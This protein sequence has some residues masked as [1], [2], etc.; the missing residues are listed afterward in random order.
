MVLL[1]EGC[2]LRA[3]IRVGFETVLDSVEDTVRGASL[4]HHLDD[5]EDRNQ[6]ASDDCQEDA[7]PWGGGEN[8]R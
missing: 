4:T 5:E 3:P 1:S 8:G 2:I 7:E 6:Q